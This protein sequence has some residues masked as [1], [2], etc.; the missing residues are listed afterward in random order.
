MTREEALHHLG[1]ITCGIDRED[2]EDCDNACGGHP[3][4]KASGW[5]ECSADSGAKTLTE[6]ESLIDEIYESRN[7]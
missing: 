7:A 6:L 4:V 2:T 1:Q 3:G 5:W